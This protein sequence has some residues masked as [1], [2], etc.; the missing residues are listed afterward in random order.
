MK[1]MTKFTWIL[2]DSMIMAPNAGHAQEGNGGK[3]IEKAIHDYFSA[4]SARYVEGLRAVLAKAFTAV[5]AAL[6]LLTGCSKSQTTQ[7]RRPP[8]EGQHARLEACIGLWSEGKQAEAVEQFTSVDW[9]QVPLFAPGDPLA[10]SDEQIA[11]LPDRDRARVMKKV[12][13]LTALGLRVNELGKKAAAGR[14]GAKAE[15]YSTSVSKCGEALDQPQ[16]CTA[17]RQLGMM[18]RKVAK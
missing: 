7:D 14:N 9:S 15:K 12:D 2:M 4:V 1:T 17:L 6:V 8:E 16:Y 13:G 11:A 5:A 18:F 10:L 3:G